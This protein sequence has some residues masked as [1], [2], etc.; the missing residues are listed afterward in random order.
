[1]TFGTSGRRFAADEAS[2]L[3]NFHPVGFATPGWKLMLKHSELTGRQLR[4][5]QHM[6]M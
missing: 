4:L 2:K 3:D 5:I 1:M 6:P